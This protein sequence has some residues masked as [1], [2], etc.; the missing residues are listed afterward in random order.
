MERSPLV[1]LIIVTF[2]KSKAS[3]ILPSNVHPT[4]ETFQI[5]SFAICV[6]SQFHI[7]LYIYIYIWRMEGCKD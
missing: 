4:N 5:I 2:K 6:I 1:T 7:G 3:F